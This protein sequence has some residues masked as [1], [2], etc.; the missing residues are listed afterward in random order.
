MV[1][2]PDEQVVP[3]KVYKYRTFNIRKLRNR[4]GSGNSAYTKVEQKLGI[5]LV[6][7]NKLLTSKI[8]LPVNTVSRKPHPCWHLTMCLEKKLS[9]TAIIYELAVLDKP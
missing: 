3:C 9:I 8:I 1:N 2:A 7:N 5:S 6:F 4:Y